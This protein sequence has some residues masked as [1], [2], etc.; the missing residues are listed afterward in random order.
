M[1]EPCEQDQG[2]A[3]RF[4]LPFVLALGFFDGA[5]YNFLPITFP[6][7]TRQFGL[8]FEQL[9]RVPLVFFLSTIVFSLGG[10]WLIA[11]LGLRRAAVAILGLLVMAF[12]IIACM[13]SFPMLLMGAG[14]FGLAV[15]G[16]EVLSAAIITDA[17]GDKRQSNFF[18]WAVANAIGA[19]IGPAVFGGFIRHSAIA[20][21]TWRVAYL[22]SAAAA[23][24]FLLWPLLLRSC[25]PS[26]QVSPEESAATA[27]ALMVVLKRPVIYALGVAIFLHGVAQIGMVSWVGQIYLARFPIDPEQ[28]AYFISFNS[29]GFFVGRSLMTW[30]TGRWKIPELTLLACCAG[31]G[32]LAYIA[33]IAAPTYRSGLLLFAVAGMLIS[34]NGPCINSYTG[35]RFPG[36]VAT[37]FAVM[38]GYGNIGSASGPY[39]VGLIGNRFG[40]ERGI[41]FLP[42]FSL[43]LAAFALFWRMDEKRRIAR[44]HISCL[45]LKS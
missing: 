45:S 40:L 44:A 41:W 27:G 17:L 12:L 13:A 29:A 37:A 39:F 16:M 36:A 31:L 42:A 19:T 35:L 14:L 28:A 34:G 3:R 22:G 6:V 38:N 23:A 30:L 33:T 43:T 24:A 20:T 11:G 7:F 9:G 4:L 26:R 5:I 21:S 2:K 25:W 10:G 15:V 8:T 1:N 18:I 32:S